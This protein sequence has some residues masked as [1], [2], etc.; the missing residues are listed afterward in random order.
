MEKPNGCPFCGSEN[1]E[2]MG[3]MDFGY[4]KIYSRIECRDCKEF[5]EDVYTLTGIEEA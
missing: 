3:D 4:N 1:I 2:G 5:W